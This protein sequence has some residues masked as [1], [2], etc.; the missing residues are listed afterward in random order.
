[1]RA[2]TKAS[3]WDLYLQYQKDTGRQRPNVNVPV[4]MEHED[5]D[6]IA[7][8]QV[9]M[10]EK[11]LDYITWLEDK[12]ADQLAA[13]QYAQQITNIITKYHDHQNQS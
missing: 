11:I 12:V 10:P 7:H 8:T 4:Q 9:D 13:E 6:G 2:I 3:E 1:M 5:A